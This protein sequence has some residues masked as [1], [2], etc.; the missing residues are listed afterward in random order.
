M[1]THAGLDAV[2]RAERAVAPID[3]AIAERIGTARIRGAVATLRAMV[4]VISERLD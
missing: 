2:T 4:E 3:Q 1:L